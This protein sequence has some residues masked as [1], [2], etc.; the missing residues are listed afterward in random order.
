MLR[1]SLED[2]A[3][4]FVDFV[5]SPEESK[6]L[7]ELGNAVDPYSIDDINAFPDE[8][9]TP[10]YKKAFDEDRLLITLPTSFI[11]PEVQT[12]YA[13]GLE[14]LFLGKSSVDEVLK[15]MDD[16]WDKGIN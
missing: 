14:S 13:S 15:S 7:A 9:D 12:A 16:A 2:A 6:R 10:E 1:E 8:M 5:A 3:K 11:N 4:A